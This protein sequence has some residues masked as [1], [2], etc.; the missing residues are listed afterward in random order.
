MHEHF[1]FHKPY[2]CLSQFV[3]E[4]KRKGSKHLLGE[5]YQYPQGTMAIGR[6]DEN[7]EG[8]LLLTTDGKLSELVRSSKFEK[9]YYVQVQGI[10]TDEAMDKLRN[11][12]EIG[13]EGIKYL[14]QACRVVRINKPEHVALEERRIRNEDHGPSSWI[15][16]TLREGKFRQ[17]RK[18]TYAVGFPTLRLVRYR[19]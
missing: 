10:I 18:M 1:K 13:F 6:L 7:S 8:L 11:G 19:I 14:T 17:V 4:G 2:N 16:I 9:E 15:S 3:Y 12:V 5:F